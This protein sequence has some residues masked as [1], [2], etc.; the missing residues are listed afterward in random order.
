M[1]LRYRSNRNLEVFVFKEKREN[2]RDNERATHTQ[3]RKKM[4]FILVSRYLARKY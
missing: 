1:F 4:H 2:L 3:K